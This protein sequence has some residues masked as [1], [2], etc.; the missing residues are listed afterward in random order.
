MG[1]VDF[2]L[3]LAG[4]LLWLNWRSIR[5][6]PLEKRTPATLMGTL[7]PAEPKKMRRWHLLVFIV[8]LL[9]L[10]ALIYRWIGGMTGWTAQLNLDVVVLSFRSD[11]LGR[12]MLFSFLSFALALGIFYVVLLFLSLLKGP[13]PIRRLIKIP[14]G[15]LDDWPAW[16]KVLLPLVGGAVCWWSLTWLLSW[17][18][19][20]PPPVSMAQRIEE[21]LVIGLASYLLW[22]FPLVALLFLHLLNSYIYFGKHPV[23][24]YVDVT[25]RKLLRPLKQIPLRAGRVD[26]APL[27]GIVIIFFVSR[28]LE[29]G[30]EMWGI[31]GLIKIYGRLPF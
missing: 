22:K 10:R 29:N 3:N 15:G 26:F 17:Q 7:R 13:D 20:C 19:I 4:L 24:N 30:V 5:F 27:M 23:W 1:Y 14:L 8:G 31:P 11:L 2:I 25:S 21:A 9:T 28:L 12:I 16:A 18:Q 6:D